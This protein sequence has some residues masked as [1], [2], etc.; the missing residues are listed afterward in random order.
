MHVS[1]IIIV[2]RYP[3]FKYVPYGLVQEVVPYLLRRAQENASMMTGAKAD[4][5]LLKAELWRR[6][7]EGGN[8]WL[9]GLAGLVRSRKW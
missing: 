6:A 3:A 1:I 8:A 9:S 2:I 7:R 5:Q 4:A